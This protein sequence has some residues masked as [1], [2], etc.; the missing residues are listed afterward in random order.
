[1][2][3]VANEAEIQRKY[4]ALTGV[5]DERMRRLWAGAE[6]EFSEGGIA[7]V[8]RATGMS[9]T[10]IR[11]G[12]A[13]LREGVTREE[14]VNVRRPGGGRTP[15]EEQN[16]ELVT[17][18]EAL[19]DPVTRGDPESALR[20]TAKS[21]RKL[22]EELA[23]AGPHGR[24]RRRSVSCCTQAATA[25]R[26]TARPSRARRIRTATRSSSTSTTRS[27]RFQARGAAGD[28]GGYEEE[29]TRRRF[30]ERRAGMAALG[31]ARGGAG[32]RFPRPEARQGDPLR[33]VRSGA[34][35]QA[36]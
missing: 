18:L 34:T 2:V 22:A 30:Q 7:A 8:E 27:R 5:M 10:T 24:A 21:T 17:A 1:M 20:W 19:V 9:R 36:G 31:R 16:P 28:L 25:C 35:T 23:A 32:P 13:E 29:G 26:P 12:R 4:E 14:V 6:A 3:Q 15:L 33:R 11:A